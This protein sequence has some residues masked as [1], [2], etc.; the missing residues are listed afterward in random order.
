MCQ[1]IMCH[2]AHSKDRKV[3]QTIHDDTHW[4]YITAIALNYGTLSSRIKGKPF[5]WVNW[6]GFAFKI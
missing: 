3:K 1:P 6:Q 5:L 2:S 4:Q